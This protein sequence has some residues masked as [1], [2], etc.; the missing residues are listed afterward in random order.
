MSPNRFIRI[1]T[2]VPW[3]TLSA[4]AAVGCSVK[5]VYDILNPPSKFYIDV[6]IVLADGHGC[7][8]REPLDYPYV[9][10]VLAI[11]FVLLTMAV[12]WLRWRTRGGGRRD[13]PSES[14]IPTGPSSIS[15]P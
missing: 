3:I 10:D 15:G 6:C 9:W 1:V 11:T 7:V 8:P 12:C 2:S 5:A 4:A 13:T 14:T